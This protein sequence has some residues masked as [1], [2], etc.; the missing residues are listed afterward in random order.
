MH[1]ST[2]TASVKGKKGI[3]PTIFSSQKMV[4]L[5]IVSLFIV[6][7]TLCIAIPIMKRQN[8]DDEGINLASLG[9]R[10]FSFGLSF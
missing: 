1:S 8:K 2:S 3:E 6:V 4:R 7:I 9:K 5:G 10:T